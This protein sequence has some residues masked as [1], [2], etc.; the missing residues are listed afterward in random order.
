MQTIKICK[1]WGENSE[2]VPSDYP[3]EIV[4]NHPI[5]KELPQNYIILSDDEIKARIEVHQSEAIAIFEKQNRK[6]KYLCNDSFEDPSN[7]FIDLL[8]LKSK[9]IYDHVT[10]ELAEI[11]HYK[12]YDIATDT[13]SNL[14]VR[15]AY[16]TYYHDDSTTIKCQVVK[17][18]WLQELFSD[19]TEKEIIGTSKTITST[20]YFVI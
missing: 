8:P 16:Q 13:F 5:D 19:D 7:I 15:E 12:D 9:K 11:H 14:A 20:E 4:E 3:C 2:G 6:R 17:I 10:L 1:L 18:D